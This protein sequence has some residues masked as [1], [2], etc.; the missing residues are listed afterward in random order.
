MA[1]LFISQER[2][3]AWSGEDRVKVDGD[4]MT[5]S[6][7]G[8]SFRLRPAVRFMKVSGNAEDLHTLL[9]KV[10]TVDA[11]QKMGG[12][13]YLESVILGETAYDV[14]T[15]FV[16]EPMLNGTSAKPQ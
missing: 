4:V 16:G 5:L 11:L 14:Q 12:E 3:D 7:D 1:R 2:L 13:H 15:G 9:G 10:K 6:N 8:R